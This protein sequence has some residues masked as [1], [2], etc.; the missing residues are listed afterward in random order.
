MLSD[1]PLYINTIFISEI[2]QNIQ[3]KEKDMTL[4]EKELKNMFDS[5]DLIK[6]KAYSGKSMIGRLDEDLRVKMSFV[7]TGVADVYSALRVKII[8]RTEGEVDSELF[9]FVDI[10]GTQ[11]TAYNNKVDPH[12]W[13]VDGKDECYLPISQNERDLIADTVLD[14]VEMY[15]EEGLTIR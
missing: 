12:I 14:Y 2:L 7:T 4:F 13:H 10:I 5:S 15:Q 8:N 3:K 11:R 6:E 1:V 9:K